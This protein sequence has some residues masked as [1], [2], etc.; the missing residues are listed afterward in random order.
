MI[1]CRVDGFPFLA[2]CKIIKALLDVNIMRKIIANIN[3]YLNVGSFVMFG[4]YS[5]W[6]QIL[7]IPNEYIYFFYL[8]MN[9]YPE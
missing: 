3:E 6:N 1:D 7:S 2:D 9:V 8:F 5:I 4:L